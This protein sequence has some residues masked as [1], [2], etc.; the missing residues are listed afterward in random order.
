MPRAATEQFGNLD[1]KEESVLLFPE[2]LPGF[3]TCRRFVLLE[4]PAL[5]PLVHLQSLEIPALCFL[6]IPVAI[7]DH[8]YEAA[9]LLEH[10]ELLQLKDAGAPPL[11][12]A[13]LAAAD[14]GRLTANLMAPVA[15]NLATRIAVQAVRDDIRYSHC[16]VLR[17]AGACS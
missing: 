2:G 15:I 14:E 13:L 16:H 1:Y 6:T 10:A 8:T 4:Q 11:L 7:I 9:L 12:L 5:A 17:E 3:E